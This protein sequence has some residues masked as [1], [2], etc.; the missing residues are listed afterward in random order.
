MFNLSAEATGRLRYLL[1]GIAGAL[2]YGVFTFMQLVKRGQRPAL[3][4]YG[5]AVLSVVSE[6][7]RHLDIGID[8]VALA[9]PVRC[10]VSETTAQERGSADFQPDPVGV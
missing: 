8:R 3:G 2:I 7:A 10:P 4:D 1:G 9:G 6:G 5:R